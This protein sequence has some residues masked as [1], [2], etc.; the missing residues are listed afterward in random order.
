[1]HIHPHATYINII[2]CL[3]GKEH[4]K[5]GFPQRSL[6]GPLLCR[7][8]FTACQHLLVGC[9]L[10]PDFT[11][12]SNKITSEELLDLMGYTYGV[13]DKVADHFNVTKVKGSAAHAGRIRPQSGGSRFSVFTKAWPGSIVDQLKAAVSKCPPLFWFGKLILC[14]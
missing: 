5:W 13:M 9:P 10:R 8:F 12:A 1:M 2:A 3:F 11:T 14:W 6:T 4:G 7:I